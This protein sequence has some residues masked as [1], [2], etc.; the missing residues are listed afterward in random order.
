[1]NVLKYLYFKIFN[2]FIIF[3]NINSIARPSAFVMAY[4]YITTSILGILIPGLTYLISKKSFW[5][6]YFGTTGSCMLF[7]MPIL[8]YAFVIDSQYW[9]TLG[10]RISVEVH[11]QR[12]AYAPLLK[13]KVPQKYPRLILD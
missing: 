10:N 2:F 7:T 4:F 1:M 3:C 6:S 11:G 13:R 12:N 5:C 9:R 8:Y